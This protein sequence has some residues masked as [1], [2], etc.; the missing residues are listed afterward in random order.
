M[1]SELSTM[2]ILLSRISSSSH[3]RFTRNQRTFSSVRLA[4]VRST[5]IRSKR[6]FVLFFSRRPGKLRIYGTSSNE[7][8][9]MTNLSS[10][11]VDRHREGCL[12]SSS[13][14][15]SPPLAV[16]IERHRYHGC[17]LSLSSMFSFL[18]SRSR[19]D[20]ALLCQAI[21]FAKTKAT[22]E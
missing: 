10:V 19:Y 15:L 11:G 6:C 2:M 5:S 3:K 4:C 14:S 18:S 1:R 20:F 21:C 9:P 16:S 17:P 12:F 7:S 22:I 13:V 8:L